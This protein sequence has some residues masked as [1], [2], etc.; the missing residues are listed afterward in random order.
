M[1]KNAEID[2]IRRIV[3]SEFT[4]SDADVSAADT[5]RVLLDTMRKEAEEYGITEAE[6]IRAVLRTV[7]REE[8]GCECYSCRARREAEAAGYATAP[9]TPG[10]HSDNPIA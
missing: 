1:S 7:F 5:A 8:K 3:I 2:K 10:T 9:D 6:V 4:G